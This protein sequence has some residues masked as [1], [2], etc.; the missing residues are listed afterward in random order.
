[1]RRVDWTGVLAAGQDRGGALLA[2]T[3]LDMGM[4]HGMDV[5]R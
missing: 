1:M 5:L 2:E 4:A 3:S